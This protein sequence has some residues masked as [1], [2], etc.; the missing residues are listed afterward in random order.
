MEDLLLTIEE[1]AALIVLNLG[2]QSNIRP[3]EH[4]A[5]EFALLNLIKNV[6]A[7]THKSKILTLPNFITDRNY[8]VDTALPAGAT[9]MAVY[10]M[11]ECK[12]AN[13]GF[14]IGDR[15]TAPVPYPA[16]NGRTTA[17]GVGIQYNNSN[18]STIKIVVND[19]LT[20]M[21]PYSAV[22]NAV[23]DNISLSGAATQ[24]W[25]IK[26]FVNYI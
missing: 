23:A 10:A 26:L 7:T 14:A 22:A 13:N 16:D 4:R 17:Q 9:I 3:V 11:L 19:Q 24:N 12:T 6:N 21:T 20:I 15:V 5:V 2:D 25:A 1:T 18:N 8:S